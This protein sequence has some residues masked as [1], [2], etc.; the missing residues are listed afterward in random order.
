[1]QKLI[2]WIGVQISWLAFIYWKQ[3]IPVQHNIQKTLKIFVAFGVLQILFIESLVYL[4][5]LYIKYS[6]FI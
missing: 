2:D 6:S 4:S 5:F 1:M 3:F